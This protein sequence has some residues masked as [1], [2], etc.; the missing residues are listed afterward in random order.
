MLHVGRKP[1]KV[2]PWGERSM[3]TLHLFSK[4]AVLGTGEQRHLLSRG[5]RQ[6]W[7]P[8]SPVLAQR[9]RFFV[10]AGT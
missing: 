5:A 6:L 2:R 3:H 9:R 1:W 10:Q 7:H 4:E 8:T